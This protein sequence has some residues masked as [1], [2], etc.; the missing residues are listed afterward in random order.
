MRGMYVAVGIGLLLAVRT[1]MAEAPPPV[2]TYA[3]KYHKTACSLGES[4]AS[5]LGS[6]KLSHK[7]A[8]RNCQ[9]LAPSAMGDA[10]RAEFMRC[11][12]AQ[13]VGGA[14]GQPEKPSKRPRRPA[15]DVNRL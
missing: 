5:K 7:E 11:C 1:V 12:L 15:E 8:E 3:P 10:D 4:L 13:L 9:M 14:T 6:K 2:T